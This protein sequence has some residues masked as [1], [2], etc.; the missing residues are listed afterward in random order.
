MSYIPVDKKITI[1]IAT[2]IL[3]S[4]LFV[5]LANILVGSF[6][7]RTLVAR[8]EGNK[9]NIVVV[10]GQSNAEGTNSF[11]ETWDA[12][13]AAPLVALGSHPADAE[14]FIWWEGADGKAPGTAAEYLETLNNPN[15]NKAGW[16]KSRDP[17]PA[18]PTRDALIRIDQLNQ[19][20]PVGQRLG[21]FGPEVGIARELYDQGKRDI[22]ILKVSYGFRAL[23]QANSQLIPYDWNPKSIDKS[24]KHLTDR[25]TEL[26]G[27]LASKGDSYQTSGIFWLQGETDTLD[28]SYTSAF[29]ANLELLVDSLKTDLNLAD[30]G[31]IVIRKFSLRD[32]LSSA[33]PLEGNYCGGAYALQ[34]EGITVASLL[35]AFEVNPL[36]S[37]P[38]NYSRVRQVRQAIQDTA[39]RYSWVDAVETDDLSFASDHIHLDW[40]GQLEMGKRMAKMFNMPVFT[41]P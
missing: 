14:T 19:P 34:L 36:I 31:H 27:Y 33:Y 5:A 4:A 15:Y 25:Y 37:I 12:N 29:P 39:N 9:W 22:I 18:L 13:A 23:A 10:A 8:A 20:S 30:D 3:I 11:I 6:H 17:D 16:L 7:S 26:T 21:Q 41:Q 38:I 35:A 24:Y 2:T 32:C 28:S 1:T 40:K